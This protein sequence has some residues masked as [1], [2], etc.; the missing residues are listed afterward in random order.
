[1]KKPHRKGSK[2]SHS[3][4]NQER[5]RE[6]SDESS[7]AGGRRKFESDP[8]EPKKFKSNSAQPIGQA[9]KAGIRSS[10]SVRNLSS[11]AGGGGRA[12]TRPSFS[13]SASVRPS[14]KKPQQNISQQRRPTE[15]K[16]QVDQSKHI[17]DL[18]FVEG[19]IK[20]HPDGYGFLIPDDPKHPDIYVS[21]QFMTSIM[22]N[23][24]IK[25]LVHKSRN[26]DRLSGEVVEVLARAVKKVVGKFLPVDVKYGVILD[27]GRRWGT[28]LRIRT[29]DSMNAK[30]NDVVVVEITSYPGKNQ[31]FTGKVVSIIGDANDPM[32]DVIRIVHLHNIPFEFS[33]L[34][35]AQAKT[36]SPYVSE[37]DMAGRK[38][39]RDKNLIT[40]DGA[41]AKDFDDAIYTEVD[42]KGWRVWVAI[43]DVSHY[44]QPGS[45][46][47]DDAYERGTS[48]Y[49]PNFVVPMLP[50]ALSNE[51]CS[52]KPKVNR[53]CFVCEMQLDAQA[54]I[55]KHEFYEA[56]M[57]SK[58]RVTYGE[59]QE[60]IDGKTP[61]HMNHIEANIKNSR[62]VAKVLMAKRYREGSLDLEIPETQVIVNEAGEA[63]DIIKSERLFAHRLIEE[64]M[65]AANVSVARF[66][67]EHNIPA[68]YRIHEEPSEEKI[69]DLQKFLW[70]FGAKSSLNSKEL[71]QI[72]I[73]KAL[74]SFK[75]KP[76]QQILSMLTLRAM[77]QAKY[78]SENLGHFGL[79]FSHYTHFT[80]P[81]RRYPDLIAHRLLKSIIYPKYKSWGLSEDQLATASSMLSACEQ[82]S[83]KAERQLVS[84]KKARFMQKFVGEKFDGVI[85][86]VARFG[87][88]VNLRAF[89]VDGLVKIENLGN[90]KF[91]FDP[92]MLLLLGSRTKKKF[93]IGDNIEVFV[94]AVDIDAGKI[95]FKLE[96]DDAEDDRQHADHGGRRYPARKEGSRDKTGA[97]RIAAGSEKANKK[98]SKRG[99][100]SGSQEKSQTPG[101]HIKKRG[102]DADDRSSLRKKR[103]SK[104][105]RKD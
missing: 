100:K 38:D 55:V 18:K 41:T 33:E 60:I 65:L 4:Q 104:R 15:N 37:K 68:I 35:E 8:S 22:T 16:I 12:Q 47:D 54:N 34:T 88:F 93:K 95:D 14:F 67:G 90:D 79:G 46:I 13:T 103:F 71:L 97:K 62:D 25:V 1:M 87:I 26:E 75:G 39:L 20:C 17:S 32:N 80:S 45:A 36:I 96:A 59:A 6:E 86:S 77:N 29:E 3:S 49:F 102:S 69:E 98:K 66:L 89:D 56:V 31:D 72:N 76:E 92:E 91:N 78:S 48:V 81:I 50:E 21:R 44:V 61:S 83:V 42:G 64:L 73:T 101:E 40:I 52:L 63:V 7:N 51:L 28:D 5:R 10:S 57:E 53:L 84:I 27:E 24:R 94:S 58:A 82:R 19:I 99:Q 70:N 105:S 11:I 30:E 9:L 2:K 74:E 23:D 85:S 43:A